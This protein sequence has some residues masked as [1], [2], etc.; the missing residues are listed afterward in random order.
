MHDKSLGKGSEGY[1]TIKETPLEVH[2]MNTPPSKDDVKG[3]KKK[4]SRMGENQITKFKKSREKNALQMLQR[5]YRKSRQP[6]TPAGNVAQRVEQ[7]LKSGKAVGHKGDDDFKSNK[8]SI[9]GKGPAKK[10]QRNNDGGRTTRDW[11]DYINIQ[12]RQRGI[13]ISDM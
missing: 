1:N 6:N 7:M 8:R 2:R 10:G 3:A 9:D 12:A 11:H 4:K 5:N 13:D